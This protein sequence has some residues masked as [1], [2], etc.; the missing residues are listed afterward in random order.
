MIAAVEVLQA[1]ALLGAALGGL[2]AAWQWV[3]KP[4]HKV[5]TLLEL[6][7]YELAPN[8]GKS[9]RDAVDRIE[10]SQVLHASRLDRIDTR[11]D[12]IESQA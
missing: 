6:V 1:F 7:E 12:R 8:H 11:L 3:F 9:L 10:R 5:A 4:T 2:G